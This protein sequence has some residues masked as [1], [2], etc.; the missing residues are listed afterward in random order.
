[1]KNCIF[2][3]SYFFCKPI[4]GQQITVL[5]SSYSNIKIYEGRLKTNILDGGG[6]YIC[7]KSKHY[8]FIEIQSVEWRNIIV[9][10]R[11]E[12]KLNKQFFSITKTMSKEKDSIETCYIAVDSITNCKLKKEIICNEIPSKES[13]AISLF[14]E[15]VIKHNL[16]NEYLNFKPKLFVAWF[17]TTSS[18]GTT[19][20]QK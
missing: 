6:T 8:N 3:I 20:P 2:F 14:S 16:Q 17:K 15:I 19:L 1:M 9:K 11:L 18:A 4:L 7:G 5:D 13:M 10:Y 12:N